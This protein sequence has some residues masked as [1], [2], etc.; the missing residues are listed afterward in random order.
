LELSQIKYFLAI[1]DCLNFTHAADTCAISQPALSK[2]IRKLEDT[3]GAELFDRSSKGV[4]LTEFGQTMRIHFE[5]IEDSRRRAQEA[6]KVASTLKI[7]RL[8][9]GVMCTI[10]P[11]RFTRFLK[12]FQQ[13]H[14]LIEVTL[15]D[16]TGPRIPDLLLSGSINCVFSANSLDYDQRF[17]VIQLFEEKLGLAFSRGHRFVDFDEISLEEI[18]KEPYLDRLHCEFRSGFLKFTK[19]SGL[20]LNVVVRSE[21]EDWIMELIKNGMGVSVIPEGSMDMHGLEHRP[22]SNLSNSRKLE[23]ILAN[24]PDLNPALKKFEE[25]AQNFNWDR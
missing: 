19:A 14:P 7:E 20:F 16:V 13:D 9:V 25:S 6:A 10:G 1:A 4:K 23:L 2:A 22:V 17:Q 18:V 15:H 3:L 21:R 5:R 24:S 12:K 11:H 8:D